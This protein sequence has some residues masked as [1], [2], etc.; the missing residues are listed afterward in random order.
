[1]MKSLWEN[2]QTDIVV[3]GNNYIIFWMLFKIHNERWLISF[4]PPIFI[5]HIYD[6]NSC[7]RRQ[8]NNTVIDFW[9]IVVNKMMNEHLKRRKAIISLKPLTPIGRWRFSLSLYSLNNIAVNFNIT[10]FEGICKC[11]QQQILLEWFICLIH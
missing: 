1:M 2:F 9:K 8:N 10:I 5:H 3:C 7:N 11:P 6:Y 4:V